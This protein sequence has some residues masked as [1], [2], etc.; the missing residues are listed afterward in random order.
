[1]WLDD[2][3][4]LSFLLGTITLLHSKMFRFFNQLTNQQTKIID[5]YPLCYIRRIH[6][7][8]DLWQCI[9]L[10]ELSVQHFP[11][12][13]EREMGHH[14]KSVSENFLQNFLCKD[15]CGFHRLWYSPFFSI[16]ECCASP[17][18]LLLCF[19]EK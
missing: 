1:M 3:G 10:K 19:S 17:V 11:K 18:V 13:D 4:W 7:I 14:N 15:S 5:L 6:P 2:Y 16:R 8:A 12:E 9:G